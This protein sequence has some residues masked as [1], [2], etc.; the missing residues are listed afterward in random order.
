MAKRSA[1]VLLAA[2]VLGS[3]ACRCGGER[4]SAHE[5]C[6]AAASAI[7]GAKPLVLDATMAELRDFFEATRGAPRFVAFL[8]PTC[9]ACQE[10]ARAIRQRIVDANK[11]RC[12]A[13]AIVWIAMRPDDD[14]QAL[15]RASSAAAHPRVR[16][17]FD[18]DH[19]AG[20]AFARA[21]FPG[22]RSPAWDVYLFYD[23][24]ARWEQDEPPAPVAKLA[25]FL[26]KD[27]T[28]TVASDV[29]ADHKPVVAGPGTRLGELLAER[30]TAIDR[31]PTPSPSP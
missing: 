15:A 31:A 19:A 4:P 22:F 28:A 5:R 21:A 23:A 8:S 17:F 6:P 18:R 12:W 24:T 1:M 3:S 14:E 25:Q 20:W 27:G 26:G 9:P 29:D 11:T 7:E 13:I 30:L 16:Q 10:G 2:A